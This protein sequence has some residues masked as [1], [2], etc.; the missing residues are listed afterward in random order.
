M[1]TST[2]LDT[3]GKTYLAAVYAVIIVSAAVGNL[4]PAFLNSS[5]QK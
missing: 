3:V 4:V 1:N 2:T 5:E